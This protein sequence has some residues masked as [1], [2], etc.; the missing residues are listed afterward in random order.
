MRVKRVPIVLFSL[1]LGML[2]VACNRPAESPPCDPD[3]LVAPEL[4]SPAPYSTIGWEP[5]EILP[6]DML[7]WTYPGDCTPESFRLEMSPDRTFANRRVGVV[8]GDRTGW[9]DPDDEYPQL[10]LEPATE[11]F[12]RVRAE[13]GGT[14]GPW[15][16]MRAFFTEPI[17][18][19]QAELTPPELLGPEDGAELDELVAELHYRVADGGCLPQGYF[20]DLQTDPDFGGSTLLATYNIPGTYVFTEELQDCT[21]YYWRVAPVYDGVQGPFSETRSFRTRVSSACLPSAVLPMTPFPLPASCTSAGE[22]NAP[23]PLTPAN[24]AHVG[25]AVTESRDESALLQW[26][27][28]GDC[29]PAHFIVEVSDAPQVATARGI[30][31]YTLDGT[32]HD[33]GPADAEAPLLP[34]TEYW[35]RV[36][37]TIEFPES[38]SDYPYI[39]PWSGY[40]AFFTGP[41]CASSAE[42]SAPELR[43]P[44]DGETLDSTTAVLQYKPPEDG[45]VPEGYYIDLQTDP[46]FGGTTDY[47]E[48][49]LPGTTLIT[50]PLEDCTS[51]YWRVAQIQDGTQGPFSEARWFFINE[52]GTCPRPIPH[53]SAPRN[54]NCRYGP[55][56][57][58]EVI[59]FLLE[60]QASPIVAQNPEGTWLVIENPGH[61]GTCWVSKPMVQV[62][63][64]LSG[65]PVRQPPPLPTPTPSATPLVCHEKLNRQQCEAAGGKWS[66][67][68]TTAPYCI[69][70]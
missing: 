3:G 52:S 6:P 36:A 65:L 24:Y 32:D 69:C 53:A 15:S 37:A 11:Y 41:D 4:V 29:M 61:R 63:G 13:S 12:W 64:D 43:W 21:T 20:V 40:R 48:Y 14:A 8:S 59:G 35:W 39:G 2:P 44:H 22:L 34:A 31:L 18:A 26:T 16:S 49:L 55:S 60:G 27:Y 38:E 25:T 57:A 66:D 46:S 67:S 56:T 70:P 23:D 62:F 33:W 30:T 19:S 28:T 51:Y 50:D 7:Q 58:Y 54:L 68:V 42:L 9:P 17:C 45:C 47:G 1:L 10:A 5:A